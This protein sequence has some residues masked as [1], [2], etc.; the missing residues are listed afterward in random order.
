MAKKKNKKKAKKNTTPQPVK[1]TDKKTETKEQ[2]I[3]TPEIIETAEI[4]EDIKEV[5]ELSQDIISDE[6][7]FGDNQGEKSISKTSVVDMLKE[8]ADD[9]WDF[10]SETRKISVPLIVL[11]YT[12]IVISVTIPIEHANVL[13]K[14]ERQQAQMEQMASDK[15]GIVMEQDVPVT[16][17]GE[18]EAVYR[19]HEFAKKVKA[20]NSGAY[21]NAYENTS[22]NNT[23]LDVRLEYTYNGSSPIKADRLSSM[24]L[25]SSDAQYSSFAAIETDDGKNIEFANDIEIKSG[26]SVILHYIFDVPK[27]MA[28]G[29]NE[30]D[31]SLYI[32]NVPYTIKL[33]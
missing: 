31:I 28:D 30:L 23:Y 33:R 29:S 24:T 14:I 21:G 32:N 18:I 9:I 1:N 17:S 11:V 7:S 20:Q 10:I 27:D 15:K 3:Q 22:E 2:A 8:K 4:I 13:S 12:A 19:G 16:V 5:E 25:K 6:Q 26:A